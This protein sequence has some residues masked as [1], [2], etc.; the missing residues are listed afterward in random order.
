MSIFMAG[1][2]E[3]AKTFHLYDKN[4]FT[5]WNIDGTYQVVLQH[6]LI[7]HVVFIIRTV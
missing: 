2:Y 3:G 1:F 7:L 6:G 5:K 4:N